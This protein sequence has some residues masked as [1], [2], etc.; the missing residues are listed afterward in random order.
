MEHLGV[1]LQ[2]GALLSEAS[3]LKL[4]LFR[5]S[6]LSIVDA[7]SSEGFTCILH[8]CRK[9]IEPFCEKTV[10]RQFCKNKAKQ[11]SLEW[12]QIPKRIRR[13]EMD[14][15]FSSCILR[16]GLKTTVSSNTTA[17]SLAVKARMNC[18]HCGHKL[19]L[20]W[21]QMTK[22]FPKLLTQ[23]F[24]VMW[25]FHLQKW[26]WIEQMNSSLL[27]KKDVFVFLPILPLNAKISPHSI[28][29]L[30]S[31]HLDSENI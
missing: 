20:Y 6:F 23:T 4:W 12:K 14:L 28:F 5:V 1:T 11:N 7:C 3:A 18:S 29:T 24:R 13:S 17:T 21:S 15:L 19:T 9:S 27:G 16:G 31:G 10:P 2:S 8:V 30:A 26:F 25:C 22:P